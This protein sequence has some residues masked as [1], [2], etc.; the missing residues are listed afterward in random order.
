MTRNRFSH[1]AVIRGLSRTVAVVGVVIIIGIL[2]WL[3]GQSAEYTVLRARY[4]DLEATPEALERVRSELG[5]DRGP[6]VLLGRWLA[7]LA[8]GDLGTSWI[9]GRA[10]GPGLIQALG[11]SATLVAASVVVAAVTVALVCLPALRAGLLLRPRRGSGLVATGLSAIPSFLLAA[12]LLVV[13]SVWW[14]WLPPYGWDSPAHVVLPALSMGLPAGAYLGR[15]LG[16]AI[17]G[18]WSEDWVR[19]WVVSGISDARLCLAVLRRALVGLVSQLALS[20]VG[21]LAG[22][23]AVEQVFAI[24]GLGRSLLGSAAAQDIP[25]TQAAIVLLLGIAVGLGML[26]NLARR[27][28]LGPAADDKVAPVSN[29]L[30][31]GRS[32]TVVAVG[33]AGGLGL[34]VLLGWGRDPY[35]VGHDRLERPG[36]SLLLGADA[37]GRDVLARLAHGAVTTLGTAMLVVL[38]TLVLGLLVGLT[39]AWGTGLIE[40]ANAVPSVI[41]GL[42]V[43][44]VMGPSIQGAA[45]AVCLTAWA[46][47]AAHTA[48]LL[49]EVR[50]RPYVRL[51]PIWGVGPARILLTTVLPV[52]IP[53]VARHAVLRLPGRALELAALSFLGLGSRPPSPDWGL[54]LAEGID[55]VERAPWAV[56]GPTLALILA[57]VSAV[58]AAA[59]VR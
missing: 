59:R 43:T 35:A 33:A 39:G 37:S 34:L 55:Y 50:A 28:L 51:Q 19:T 16:D 45:L 49:E 30:P 42:L 31:A 56:L 24:P 36:W 52:V 6:W 12:V 23:V 27:A 17:A 4:A 48:D 2:P 8:R 29:P 58:A 46:P 9:S 22:A 1:G 7:G 44:A 25:A 38:I 21:L 13:V 57:S 11:V 47:L 26:A 41:V 15:L 5:L 32:A 3:G 14:G 53:A 40:V 18:A 20:L 10:L 54:L